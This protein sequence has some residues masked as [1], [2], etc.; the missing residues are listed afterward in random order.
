M[1]IAVCVKQVLDSSVPLRVVSGTVQQDA[2]WPIARVG[3][4][5]R[6]AIEQAFELRARP[7][8][9]SAL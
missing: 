2:P 6:A 5:D 7:G 9:P 8:G 4:A 1:N 3:A